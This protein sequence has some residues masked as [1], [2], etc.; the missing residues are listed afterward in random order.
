MKRSFLV[1]GCIVTSSLCIASSGESQQAIPYDYYTLRD[2]CPHGI[3]TINDVR[4]SGVNEQQP[5]DCPPSP[6]KKKSP[7]KSRESV[8]IDENI[9]AFVLWSQSCPVSPVKK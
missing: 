3:Y 1:F 2:N 6:V 9:G 7:N 5:S 8:E 4:I